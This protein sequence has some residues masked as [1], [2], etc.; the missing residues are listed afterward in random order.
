MSDADDS[1]DGA[2]TI[3]SRSV[4]DGGGVRRRRGRVRHAAVGT[5]RRALPASAASDAPQHDAASAPQPS[6]HNTNFEGLDGEDLINA[7]LGQLDGAAAPDAAS[8]DDGN[9]AAPRSA[10]GVNGGGNGVG[11]GVGDGVAGNGEDGASDDSG[12]GADDGRGVDA[13]QKAARAQPQRVGAGPRPSLVTRGAFDGTLNDPRADAELVDEEVFRAR[14]RAAS[15]QPEKVRERRRDVRH[16]AAR[17][18]AVVTNVALCCGGVLLAQV[19]PAMAALGF[20]TVLFVIVFLANA[21]YLAVTGR[22]L[23]LVRAATSFVYELVSSRPS[24]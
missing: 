7:L 6:I 8:V 24:M 15:L 1:S 20:F 18:G 10:P 19:H 13:P 3:V 9:N 23:A 2:P 16:R 5:S 4:L 17:S 11:V 12:D 22:P 21:V 14:Q